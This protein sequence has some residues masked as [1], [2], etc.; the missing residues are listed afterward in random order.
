MLRPVEHFRRREQAAALVIVLAIAVLLAGLAVAYLARTTS[1]RAVARGSFNQSK[2]NQLAES[3]A[4][5]VIGDVRQEI[6]NGSNATTVGSSTIYTPKTAANMLPQRSGTSD[7][8]PN[9][10]RRS[11]FP[12][13]MLSPGLASRASA[14]NSG[15]VDPANPKRGEITLPRWNKHYLIPRPVGANPTDTTPISGAGGFT[16]P[17]WVVLTRGGP[18]SFSTWNSTLAD[19]TPTNDSYAVGRYAYAVYDEGGLL[20]V[21][22]AGYPT[23]A[24]TAAQYG[25]KGVS[26]FA[27]LTALG[28]SNGGIDGLVGWRNYASAQPNGNFPNFTFN[29]GSATNFVSF[30][31]SNTNGFMAVGTSTTGGGSNIRT[32]QAFVNRQGL[33]QF[34]ASNGFTADALQYLGTF[35]RELNAPSWAPTLNASD[36]GGDTGT[37]YAYKANADSTTAINRNLLGVRVA[38]LFIRADGN[39]AN[40]GEPLIDR[41]FPLT[42]LGGLGP[43]GIVTTINSTIVN[44][45]PSVATAAT[46]QRDF[47]LVWNGAPNYRW[48]YAGPSGTTP[49]TS[50]ETLDQ[51]ANE[52]QGRE[53]NFF[54]LLKAAIL[55]GSVGLGSGADVA[56][57]RTFV[58]AEPKYWNTA[59]TTHG[60]SSDYQIIQIGANV[61]NQWDSGN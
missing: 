55:S 12:D 29:A 36:M 56:H 37:T 32:D 31:L 6:V 3:A 45:L 60:T 47:G 57:T 9:L 5:T 18:V 10:N 15:A 27:D 39:T 30:V 35:S 59:D 43:A 52:S 34:R 1:D 4:D 44:G 54:E 48:D 2:A 13:N 14:V 41:R 16:A 11:V 40:V 49:Q 22:V 26:A 38:N 25:P 17:D 21:N 19:Q 61:I 24:T 50:I 33:L 58:A 7:S 51:V 42:R 8:M 23:T 53:P 20:D 46:I 28:M